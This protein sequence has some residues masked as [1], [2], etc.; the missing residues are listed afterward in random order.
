[1][2]LEKQPVVT[3]A[4][5][6]A[7]DALVVAL[8]S[9]YLASM[10]ALHDRPS[11]C[12]HYHT[13]GQA[14]S[15]EFVAARREIEAASRAARTAYFSGLHNLA[16]GTA[17]KSPSPDTLAALLEKSTALG[18]P[19]TM[20]EWTVIKAGGRTAASDTLLCAANVKLFENILALPEGEAAAL[21][22]GYWGA[23]LLEP[24]APPT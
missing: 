3:Q 13:V 4:K 22:R 16:A 23:W 20:A 24:R 5:L 11:A 1:M 17:P 6:L 12:R 10:R 8:W 2:M 18:Q 7:D 21:I 19:L 9:R 14:S 15:T